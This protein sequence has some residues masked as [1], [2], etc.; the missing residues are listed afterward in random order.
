MLITYQTKETEEIRV[1]FENTLI[2]MI[3][4]R[5]EVLLKHK[6]MSYRQ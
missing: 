3:F 5:L 4:K 1:D 2:A 6:F